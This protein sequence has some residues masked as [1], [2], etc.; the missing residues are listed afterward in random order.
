MARTL[1][2]NITGMPL[3]LPLPF[4][5]VLAGGAA[6]VVPE[7]EQTVI[8]Y[9]GGDEQMR[10]IWDVFPVN[11]NTLLGPITIPT[12][13]FTGIRRALGQATGPVYFNNVRLRGVAN[14]VEPTDAV[15]RQYLFANTIPLTRQVIAGQGMSGGGPLDVGDVTL[16]WIGPPT[17]PLG[18]V[19]TSDG[20][21]A[22]YSAPPSGGGGPLPVGGDLYGTTAAASVGGIQNRQVNSAA[23]GSSDFLRWN[24]AH[25]E[26]EPGVVNKLH[27][28][29]VSS[30]APGAS[31]YLRWNNGTQ[32]WEPGVVD[33]LHDKTV[34]G[35]NPSNG[36]VLTWNGGTSQWEPATPGGGGAFIPQMQGTTLNAAVITVSPVETVLGQFPLIIADYVGRSFEFHG[37]GF[38]SAV[39]V[40]VQ[41]RLLNLS[42]GLPV[43]SLT[44]GGGATPTHVWSA[45]VPPGSLYEFRA[46]LVPVG[47]PGPVPP[48]S[49]GTVSFAGIRIF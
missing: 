31:D 30:A 43:S 48:G 13:G 18:N 32:S 29:V 3:N 14:P 9:L 4:G 42:T 33:K 2:R 12:T 46:S 49:T 24:N 23:P 1:I 17:G 6:T 37:V 25:N 27:T 45:F 36:Q 11:E 16:D 22:W 20:A 21:G 47:G 39:G 10:F 44:V 41:L 19:L 34:S 35:A 8:A 28:N 26:W 7:D 5:G 15:N 38:G 40:G